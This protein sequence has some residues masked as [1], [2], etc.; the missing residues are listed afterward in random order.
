MTRTFLCHRLK[1]GSEQVGEAGEVKSEVTEA[2][3]EGDCLERTGTSVS[4]ML[5][6]RPDPENADDVLARG[7]FQLSQNGKNENGEEYVISILVA[8]GNDVASLLEGLRVAEDYVKGKG[9]GEMA[10]EAELA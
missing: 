6:A 10:N 1:S 2:V 5:D 4:L 3:P 9:Q 7:F 8:N